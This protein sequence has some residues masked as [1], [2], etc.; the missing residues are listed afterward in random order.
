MTISVAD[1]CD[2]SK[3]TCESHEGYESIKIEREGSSYDVIEKAR[4]KAKKEQ[5]TYLKEKAAAAA[6]LET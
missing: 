6:A 3:C 2:K 4:E 1:S 5:E